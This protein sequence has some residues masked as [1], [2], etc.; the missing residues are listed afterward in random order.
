MAVAHS[1]PEFTFKTNGN[2]SNLCN[3]RA[4]KDFIILT[5]RLSRPVLKNLKDF[6]KNT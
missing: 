2:L 3:K 5:T 1:Y 6:A 4:A